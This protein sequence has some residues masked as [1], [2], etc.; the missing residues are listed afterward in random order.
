M[1]ESGETMIASETRQPV[2]AALFRQMER[3]ILEGKYKKDEILPSDIDLAKQFDVSRYIAREVYSELVRRRL[4]KRVRRKGTMV[5]Y[6]R[7]TARVRK[8][9]LILLAD[10]PAYYLFEKGV[11]E[12]L[13]KRGAG[14]YVQYSY[15]DEKLN[16]KAI[17]EAIGHDV[18]G[19]IVSPPPMSSYEPYKQLIAR[20]F[21]V[22]LAMASNPE[23]T[24]VHPDD[25]KAGRL[26]GEHF[27]QIGVKRPA[28]LIQAERQ[29]ARDRLY[30]FREGVARHGLRVDDDHV[31]PVKYFDEQ[32]RYQPDVGRR[33]TM[34]LLAMKPKVDAVFAV[35][36]LIATSTYFWLLNL[37]ARVPQDVAVA[38]VDNLGSRFHPFP[39]TSVDIGLEEMGRR[40]AELLLQQLQDPR[41][42]IVQKRVEPRLIV[43]ASTTKKSR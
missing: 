16:A 32:G 3:A 28:V 20:G 23:V 40:S 12:V 42:P 29:Y 21:P 30:G 33:E 1:A 43:S 22:V 14:L 18:E 31:I 37:G 11:E 27:G 5:T 34:A 25:Y 10:V 7:A 2:Y 4:V 17:E 35:N 19:L 6:D 36:D 13:G 24:C 9:G 38:G 8:I 41:A 26:V 15:D 39:L